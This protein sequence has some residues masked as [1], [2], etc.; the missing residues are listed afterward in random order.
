[1]QAN[2]T[3]LIA[4]ESRR[5]A[6]ELDI[7]RGDGAAASDGADVKK[8]IV[9][10]H[11]IGDQVRYATIRSVIA[12]FRARHGL[13]SGVPL[14]SFY[15]ESKNPEERKPLKLRPPYSVEPFGELAF[16]EVYWAGIPRE[17]VKD[18]HALEEVKLWA[19]TIVERLQLRGQAELEKIEAEISRLDEERKKLLEAGKREDAARCS[20]R[21]EDRERMKDALLANK[22]EESDYSMLKQVLDEMIRTIAILEQLCRLAER[23]GVFTFDLGKLMDNYLGDVQVVTEFRAQRR[24]ILDEFRRV[25]ESAHRFAPNAEIYI[26]AHSEGTVVSFLGLL[27]ALSDERPP[28][29]INHVRGLMT[30]GSPIDKH[31]ILWPEELWRDFGN[32]D[33]DARPNPRIRFRPT[34][35][36]E[37]I[38]WRNYYDKGDPVG[39]EL[40]EAREW[41]SKH[42]W[43]QVFDFREENDIGF[44]RYPLP[45]KAHVDYWKDKEVFD[46]FI[47][48]VIFPKP[49]GV[50][51][52]NAESGFNKSPSKWWAPLASYVVPYIGVGAL[53]FA[54]VFI[55]LKAL[56]TCLGNNG[57]DS[58]MEIQWAFFGNVLGMTCLLYGVTVTARIPRLTGIWY[59]RSIGP[60]VYAISAAIGA[61]RRSSSI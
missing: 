21:E 26:V 25:I 19:R 17:I 9:A 16:T 54:A 22:L 10:V 23:A 56:Q 3:M 29:W 18:E 11:G 15:A 28:D 60:L 46:H 39:Y 4:T 53:L 45:G 59:W 8:V 55:L 27:E 34:T 40:D 41:M 30:L 50:Q 47:E 52:D 33:P 37:R 5:L 7:P 32:P 57:S 24:M 58:G 36:D 1:M 42:D 61:W 13:P 12:Q 20:Y 44:W 38:K 31:L 43:D 14:G 35:P 2:D 49:A 51:P 48:G 6:D